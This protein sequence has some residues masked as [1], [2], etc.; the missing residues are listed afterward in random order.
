MTAAELA[1][2]LKG[3]LVGDGTIQITRVA[4]IE[5]AGPGDLTFLANPKYEKHLVASRA[6]AV[7]VSRE[8]KPKSERSL[9]LIKVQDP[10]VAFLHAFKQLTPHIDPLPYGIDPTANISS[11]AKLGS[12]V[13][14]GAYVVVDDNAVIGNNTRI[15]HACIIGK[16]A[17]IGADCML[18]AGARV[19]HQCVLGDRVIVHSG[20]I[21]GSDGFGF[22]RNASG[23]YEKIPQLGRVVI[24]DDVEIGANTTID[25]ATLGETLIQR[26]VK[27]DNLIHVGHNVTI[28]EHTVIAA[29]T[30]ISGS[31][32]IGK[33]V[34]IGGQVGIGGHLEI[35][36]RVI[37]LGQ[38]GVTK[39][40]GPEGAVFFGYPAKEQ[41]RA[42]RIEAATRMLPELLREFQ[43][44][45][46]KLLS[47]IDEAN[48]SSTHS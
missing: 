38:S 25:R 40:L 33:H 11:S 14:L 24:E 30:G 3:E 9:T 19:Y 45:K 44:L 32:K 34:M 16:G 20:A 37:I 15:G 23:E 1:S 31:V 17:V 13:S 35:A 43:E 47:L 6:S 48:K 5:E 29:Q 42:H 4:K 36:D 21:V 12:N 10:Y 39:S 27:L 26:G 28:G 41:K 2:W 7:L 22:A 18:Y 46:T 8:F